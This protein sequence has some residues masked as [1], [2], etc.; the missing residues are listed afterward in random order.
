MVCGSERDSTLSDSNEV[1]DEQHFASVHVR[2]DASND[3][4]FGKVFGGFLKEVGLERR[5]EPELSDAIQ[6]FHQL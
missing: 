6:L 3:F 5:G 2:V 4:I 1:H